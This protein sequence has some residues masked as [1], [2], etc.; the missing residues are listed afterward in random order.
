MRRPKRTATF[1]GGKGSGGGYQGYGKVVDVFVPNKRDKW[2]KRFGFVRMVGV[3]NEYIMEKRLNEIWFGFYKLRVRIADR[4]V[5]QSL[6]Q[7]KMTRSNA[8]RLVQPGQ[9]YAQAVVGTNQRYVKKQDNEKGV[10]EKEKGKVQVEMVPVQSVQLEKNEQV[11]S[12]DTLQGQ[13]GTTGSVGDQAQAAT[14]D[15]S[16]TEEEIHWLEGGMV[17]VLKSL[18]S[19]TSIQ[20]TVDVD[21]G[22][23]SVTPLGGRS[24]LLTEKVK[25]HLGEFME[26][27][28]E[29]FNTW[30]ESIRPWAMASS[31]RS[32][33]VWLRVSGVPLKVWCDRCFSLIGGTVGDVVMVHDD[34]RNRFFLCEGRVLVLC[35][36]EFKIAKTVQLKIEGQ[37]YE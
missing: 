29:L 16:P 7:A 22:L 30:F 8:N 20:D 26:Q 4:P 6:G 36:D 21:G 15:F 1:D 12:S 18:R 2:G 9:S 13:T 32:R 10:P 11:G 24:V 19:I 17:A 25:G 23:I 5:K 27:N 31:L 28:K 3:L 34:T 33:L 37:S 14:I 35:S